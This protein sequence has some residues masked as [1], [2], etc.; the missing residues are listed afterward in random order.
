V[1]GEYAHMACKGCGSNKQDEFAAEVA[2]HFPAP[3][4]LNKPIVWV[5]PKLFLCL[6]CGKAE[7]VIPDN[8]LRSLAENSAA[9]AG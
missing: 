7:F 1:I 3:E 5:F 9:S 2:I 4:G 8:E 6:N